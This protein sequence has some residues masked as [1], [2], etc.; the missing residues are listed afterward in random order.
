MLREHAIA[1]AR[2]LALFGLSLVAAVQSAAA[3]VASCVGLMS[4]FRGERR[5]LNQIRRLVARWTDQRIPVPYRPE[6]DPPTPD[7]DGWYRS[8]KQVYRRPGPVARLDRL[9]WLLKDPASHRDHLW[10]LSAPVTSVFTVGLPVV[11]VVAGF[12]VHPLVALPTAAIGLAI[13][14]FTL[15]TYGRWTGALLRPTERTT[16]NTVWSW[17]V[18]R[19]YVLLKLA[20]TA[21]LSMVGILFIGITAAAIS[22]VLGPLAVQRQF[23]RVFVS[24]RRQQIG[25]WSGISIAQPYLPMPP[26]PVPRPDGKYLYG[27]TLYDTPHVAI[28]SATVKTLM[29]DKA[30]WRDLLWLVLDPLVTLV[31]AVLPVLM[32]LVGFF[33]YFWTW[34]WA[35]P[36]SLVTDFDIRAGWAYLGDFIPPLRDPPDGSRRSAGW[37]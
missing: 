23:G 2:G 6:P 15:Q 30:T 37:S 10:A 32:V 35:S 9:H 33:G 19:G 18:A 11:L 27:R 21:G 12:F 31:L 8:G 3:F 7:H 16:R 1:L 28:Y 34:V 26:P 4:G 29:K 22:G 25:R 13:A 17:V 14:P 20:A 5:L 36:T 24:M